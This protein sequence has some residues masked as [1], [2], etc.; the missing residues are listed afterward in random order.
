MNFNLKII[1]SP[2]FEDIINYRIIEKIL[3]ILANSSY[4]T[5]Q[6]N[7]GKFAKPITLLS[8]PSLD[9]SSPL[10]LVLNRVWIK[11]LQSF[12]LSLFLGQLNERMP[13]SL[14]TAEV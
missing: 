6:S 13:N 9:P 3:I 12:L 5:Y 11:G 2:L 10:S 14:S 1:M 8:R 4:F 7:R